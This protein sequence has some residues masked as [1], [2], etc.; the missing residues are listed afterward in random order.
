MF[1]FSFGADRNS[2]DLTRRNDIA[3]NLD[4]NFWPFSYL[5]NICCW[6]MEIRISQP[7]KAEALSRPNAQSV[8]THGVCI[9]GEQSLS[10]FFY[11]S[12][13][14]HFLSTVL[15][16]PSH[17][18]MG[19]RR[20]SE[21]VCVIFRQMAFVAAVMNAI[22][23]HSLQRKPC[24]ARHLSDSTCFTHGGSY[25]AS[26][27]CDVMFTSFGFITDQLFLHVR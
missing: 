21:V 23:V 19:R 6:G 17:W 12:A 4:M 27:S 22:C 14:L 11:F 15:A 16:I 13:T 24:A 10:S 7:A 26:L 25:W 5:Y 9:H 18:P 3:I 8:D 1:R 2:D 20:T